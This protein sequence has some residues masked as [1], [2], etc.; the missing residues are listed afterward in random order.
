MGAVRGKEYD[1]HGLGAYAPPCGQPIQEP[2]SC[3]ESS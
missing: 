3:R 1:V 2:K